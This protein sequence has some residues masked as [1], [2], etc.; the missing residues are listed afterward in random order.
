MN[1]KLPI[2]GDK[3]YIAERG[4]VE[5]LAQVFTEMTGWHL[6]WSKA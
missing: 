4:A 3:S 5:Q 1:M 2:T 6:D